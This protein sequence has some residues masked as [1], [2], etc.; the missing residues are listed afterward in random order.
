MARYAE[1]PG[2]RDAW[3]RNQILG[4]GQRLGSFWYPEEPSIHQ[5]AEVS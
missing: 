2:Q 3:E 5:P 4:L 1:V